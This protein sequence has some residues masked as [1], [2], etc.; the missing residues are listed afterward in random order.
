MM[1]KFVL[2]LLSWVQSEKKNSGNYSWKNLLGPQDTQY[3]LSTLYA[4]NHNY[5]PSQ[6]NNMYSEYSNSLG[7]K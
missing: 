7:C 3:S 2:M 6:C 1:E 4:A 5:H